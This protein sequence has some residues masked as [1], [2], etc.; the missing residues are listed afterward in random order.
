MITVGL[1]GSIGMGKSTAA[2]MLR[3]M[4][5]PVHDADA[6]VH[7]LLGPGGGA[8]AAVAAL[9]PEA[10]ASKDGRPFIDRKVLGAHFFADPALKKQVEAALYPLVE[11]AARDFLAT[12][13]KNGCPVAVLDVPLL[14]EAGWDRLVDKVICVSAPAEVQRARVLA[15]PGMTEERL[16]AVLMAQLP[17]AEKRARSDYV[18]DTGVGMDDTRAQLV[19]IAA[20]LSP[21]P[22]PAQ[23]KAPHP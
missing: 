11:Q 14:F 4:G 16:A 5:I 12:Q 1:T 6:A 8:V 9:C 18:V 10:L 23:P 17:D 20:A 22:R 19:R 13:E 2:N 3:D 15:R 7:E 21:P